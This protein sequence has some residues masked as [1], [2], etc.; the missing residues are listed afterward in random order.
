MQITKDIETLVDL[1]ISEDYISG[2]PTTE[3]FRIR[4][5]CDS[6]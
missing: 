2:D 5:S 1:A 4:I 3:S 6:F